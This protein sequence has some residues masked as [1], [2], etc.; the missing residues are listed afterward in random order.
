MNSVDKLLVHLA[1]LG[2]FFCFFFVF[3]FV[4]RER[5]GINP[6]F[7]LPLTSNLSSG[8]LSVSFLSCKRWSNNYSLANL[9]AV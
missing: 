8:F 4:D 3:F 7:T 9:T 1:V 5:H 6:I 2:F